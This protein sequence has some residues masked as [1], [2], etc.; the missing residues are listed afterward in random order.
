[1]NWGIRETRKTD[2]CRPALLPDLLNIGF[3]E[4]ASILMFCGGLLFAASVDARNQRFAAFNQ[5]WR[6]KPNSPV[7][8][9]GSR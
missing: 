5:R 6:E 9:L 7:R 2:H 8:L 4:R 1:M 3:N